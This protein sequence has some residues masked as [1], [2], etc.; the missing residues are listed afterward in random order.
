MRIRLAGLVASALAAAG[1]ATTGGPYAEITGEM[2]T[3][4]DPHE[5]EVLV[6]G[7]DGKLD[8]SI[9]KTMIIEPGRRELLLGTA[10]QDRKVQAASVIL[11][12]NAKA[13]L[14]YYFVAR[15]ETMSQ[16]QPWKLVLKNVEPIPECVAEHPDHA[17]MPSTAASKPA[18]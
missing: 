18:A 3:R 2:V 8:L 17:P 9:K 7:V 16:V 12:L 13:C 15:H 1:C 4:A 14:R 10:R 11:P 6:Y 5:E